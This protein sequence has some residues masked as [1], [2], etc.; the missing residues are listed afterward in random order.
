[1]VTNTRKLRRNRLESEPLLSRP[2]L[3]DRS[4]ESGGIPENAL[5]CRLPATVF[6]VADGSP[7]TRWRQTEST[8]RLQHGS[9]FGNESPAFCPTPICGAPCFIRVSHWQ[10]NTCELSTTAILPTIIPSSQWTLTNSRLPVS[11]VKRRKSRK[12]RIA[13]HGRRTSWEAFEQ[14]AWRISMSPAKYLEACR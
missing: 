3:R 5:P 9:L 14:L 10:T 2:V 7:I 12:Q 11:S 6:A 8:T 1:V 13:F 4:Q